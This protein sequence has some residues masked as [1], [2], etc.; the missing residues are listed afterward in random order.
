[1]AGRPMS[2]SHG[3]NERTEEGALPMSLCDCLAGKVPSLDSVG[4]E[5]QGL[6]KSWK[7]P[8]LFFVTKPVHVQSHGGCTEDTK[9][10]Y[11]FITN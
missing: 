11:W 8:D 1:M 3:G 6:K 10:S 7:P 9:M 2:S 4:R 5:L